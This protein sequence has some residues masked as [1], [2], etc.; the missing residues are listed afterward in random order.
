MKKHVEHYCHGGEETIDKIKRVLS[1]EGY[2]GF[3]VGN[4]IKYRDRAPYKGDEKGDIEKM[5]TYCTYLNEFLKEQFGEEEDGCECDAVLGFTYPPLKDAPTIKEQVLK[6]SEE[7]DEMVEALVA[8][9][10]MIAMVNKLG[11][12]VDDEEYYAE[13]ELFDAEKAVDFLIECED[14]IHAVE[15]LQRA[16]IRRFK[17]D[18]DEEYQDNIKGEIQMIVFDKN[19]ERD[20]YDL[21]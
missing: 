3:C 15:E 16:V 10:L 11:E 21:A 14:V 7:F 9:E 1:P 19:D 8:W 12:K 4:I 18:V 2:I 5:N 6:V 20:Y 13:A 17:E